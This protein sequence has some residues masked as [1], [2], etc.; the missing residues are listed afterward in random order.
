MQATELISDL[1]LRDRPF[2]F[3]VEL[4]FALASPARPG[5]Q[6]SAVL[7]SNT[8]TKTSQIKQ[9]YAICNDDPIW[10]YTTYCCT[11][12]RLTHNVVPVR[13]GEVVL[14]VPLVVFRLQEA[15]GTLSLGLPEQSHCE[16]HSAKASLSL[17]DHRDGGGGT[18]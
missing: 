3:Q 8:C 11:C 1:V 4:C 13:Q 14:V 16:T 2:H 17:D 6:I 12:T 15:R 5:F 9:T 10:V 7:H 18:K